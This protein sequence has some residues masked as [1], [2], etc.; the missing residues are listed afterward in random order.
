MSINTA[1]P[2]PDLLDDLMA[3]RLPTAR[4]EEVRQHLANCPVCLKK[5][6]PASKPSQTFPFLA[7]AEGPDELGRLGPYRIKSVLGQGGMAV[8]FDAEEP[9]LGRLVALKVL[10]TDKTD[11]TMRERFLREA[12]ALAKLPHDHIVHLYQVGEDRG[13]PYLAM[14][15]LRGESLEARLQRDRSLPVAEA[16]AVAR[17][18]AEGLAAVHEHGL[19]HRDIKPSNIWLEGEPGAPATGRRVKLIDFGIARPTTEEPGLTVAGH[20]I[21]TPTYMAP[22]QAAGWPVDGRA[23]LYGL[24]C[25]MYRMTTGHT[26][27]DVAGPSTMSVLR[28]VIQNNAPEIRKEAPFLSAQVADLIQRLLAREPAERP[29]SARAVVE[30]LRLLETQERASSTDTKLLVPPTE[31][32]K[33]PPRRAGPV[34]ILLGGLVIFAALV[35]GALMA[36]SKFRHD[37]G[38]L[39][40]GHE[41]GEQEHKAAVVPAVD[42]NNKPPVKIGLLFSRR[43]YLSVHELPVLAAAN[44]AIDEINEQGGVLGRP[45]EAVHA[46]GDSR[47]AHYVEQARILLKEKEVQAIFGCWTSASRKAVGEECARFDRLLFYPITYEGLGQMSHVIYVGGTPNQTITELVAFAANRLGKRR[48][49]LVGSESVTSYVL[50]EF[51][52]HEIEDREEGIGGKIVGTHYVRAGDSTEMERVAADIKKAMLDDKDRTLFV[53]NS[54]DG[55]P[56]VALCEALRN[57]GIRPA[58]VP[59]AWLQISEPELWMF[60]PNDLLGDY[61]TGCY[62]ESLNRPTNQE[63]VARLRKRYGETKRVNDPMES[64]YASV[65]LWKAAVEKAGSTDTKAVREAL[66]G[67]SFKAPEGPIRIDPDNMHAWRMALVG[68]VVRGQT[69]DGVTI[70]LDVE[71]VA[72]SARPLQPRP[73]PRWKT[74]QQWDTFLQGVKKKLGGAWEKPGK[75]SHEGGK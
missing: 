68:K 22:E 14:E 32:M 61:L 70:P 66:R 48:F 9:H 46:D 56:N 40:P 44:L 72:T 73:F 57:A 29:A 18:T 4:A 31:T 15:K 37:P 53:I 10:R 34:G 12:R 45:I 43:G 5:I 50:E 1:C 62:F 33:R 59:T 6:A 64:A 19:V 28:A 42:V 3:N 25:V 39:D 67:L 35:V 16:L 36:W 20:V 41:K 75:Q 74:R 52:R 38:H 23:D 69:K 63:F 55:R 54:I 7:P 51:L 21:G 27:F 60:R 30:E 58:D 17:E 11:A 47:T 71:V 65:Y 26:P 13:V 49:F 24:G 8:V 2:G